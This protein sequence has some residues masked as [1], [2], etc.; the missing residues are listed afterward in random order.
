[1]YFLRFQFHNIQKLPSHESDDFSALSRSIHGED[2]PIKEIKKAVMKAIQ[3]LL[4]RIGPNNDTN[5]T[6]AADLFN[7]YSALTE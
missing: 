4:N 2:V 1:M 5:D 3:V 7:A 6:L